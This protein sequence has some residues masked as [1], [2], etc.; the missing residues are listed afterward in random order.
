LTPFPTLHPSLR[1]I[2]KGEYQTMTKKNRIILT[3]ALIIALTVTFAGGC[4]LGISH[5]TNTATANLTLERREAIGEAW[6]IILANYV[7]PSKID[8]ANL[9][10]SAI[11]GMVKALDDPYTSYLD[12]QDYVLGQSALQGTYNG[13][14][15]YVNI[16]DNQITVIAP[17]ADSPA[18]K[19]GIKAGD[20]ILAIN[21]ESTADMNLA[22]AVIK[23]RGPSGTTVTL[24]ILHE[25]DTEPVEM[26]IKR[27]TLNAPSLHEEMKGEIGYIVIADFTERTADELATALQS[28]TDAKAKGIVLDLRGN[29]GGLLDT[30]VDV[31]SFFL[32][33]GVVVQVR[34]NQG[35]VTTYDVKG[36]IPKNKLP[37]VVLVD[38]DSASGSEVLSGALQDHGRATIA[39]T[40]TYGKGSVDQLYQLS[41]GSG[42]YITTGRWL[43]PNGRLIEGQ[44]IEPDI[45]L[46]LTGDEEVQ[47][48]V[49]Y[50]SGG[51]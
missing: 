3:I 16:K 4:I 43:T 32:T 37:M 49:D 6:D 44:G 18:A 14:G 40:T 26:E 46:T 45:T 31:A 12:P 48:A 21:G 8:S 47:W 1:D 50:L 17:I 24:L 5:T 9:S 23:I 30:V 35:K 42:L 36:S 25:G 41:D 27:E 20:I 19:A 51:L 33:D 2:E 22:Q 34:D 15:A 39:G 13:I 28:L 10:S 7:D 29:P 38:N 11:E